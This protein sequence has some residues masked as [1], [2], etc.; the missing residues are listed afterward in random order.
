MLSI[1]Q[2]ICLS[3]SQKL[4]GRCIAGI[5]I[6]TGQWIRPICDSGDGSVPRLTR[7]VEGRE[8]ELLDIIDI[9][10]ASSCQDADVCENFIIAPGP[11][12]LRGKANPT[13]VIRY[14][15]NTTDILHNP[16]KYVRPSYLKKL[17]FAQ[18]SS[19]QLV[20]TTSMTVVKKGSGW[21]GSLQTSN[22]K[23]TNASITDPVLRAKLESGYQLHGPLLV[24]VSLSLPYIPE[25]MD[26]WEGEAACWKLIAGV[27]EIPRIVSQPISTMSRLTSEPDFDDIPW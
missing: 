12:H 6:H 13:D 19:L 18:R 8:P 23:L 21:R 2:I 17:P 3:N 27:I 14:C 16:S 4:G 22:G 25:G 10:L 24:T 7:L 1:K 20:E 9:P 11:W 26:N 15:R 5:D